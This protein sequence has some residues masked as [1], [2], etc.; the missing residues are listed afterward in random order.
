M[1]SDGTFVYLLHFVY[2]SQNLMLSVHNSIQFLLKGLEEK[3]K[4]TSQPES[5]HSTEHTA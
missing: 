3:Q 2:L 4:M 1:Y 5:P